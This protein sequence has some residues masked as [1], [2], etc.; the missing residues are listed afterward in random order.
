MNSNDAVPHT[1][2]KIDHNVR[3][4]VVNNIFPDC[5]ILHSL[6]SRRALNK[7]NMSDREDIGIQIC[8]GVMIVYVEDIIARMADMFLGCPNFSVVDL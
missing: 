5:L 1:I 7:N 8:G 3:Y 4:F 6:N 2:D